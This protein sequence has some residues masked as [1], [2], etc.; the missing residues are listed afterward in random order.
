M[1][2]AKQR[3]PHCADYGQREG[4]E[5]K[6]CNHSRAGALAL[7]PIDL[8]GRALQLCSPGRSN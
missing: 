2:D 7:W 1:M 5:I 4:H 6:V 3:Q 8:G